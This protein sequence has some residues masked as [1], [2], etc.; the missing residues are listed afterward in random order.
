MNYQISVEHELKMGKYMLPA[1]TYVL[2]QIDRVDP[3]Q[4]YLYK[5]DMEHSPIAIIHA[6]TE[7]MNDVRSPGHAEFA[8]DIDESSPNAAPVLKG[9]TIPGTGR[10]EIVSVTAKDEAFLK[11]RE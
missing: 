8:L 10:W 2:Y 5:G 3:S 6:V 4:F 11:T 1:G 9:W 7:P